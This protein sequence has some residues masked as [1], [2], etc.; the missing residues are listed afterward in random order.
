MFFGGGISLGK[1]FGIVIRIDYS[2]FIIFFLITQAFASQYFLVSPKLDL[3]TSIFLGAVTSLLIFA[4]ALIH[5][6]SHSVVGNYLGAKIKRITLFI[7]GG[8]SEMSG[9]PR[10]PGA[11]F[12]IAVA[13]PLSSFALGFL[14]W[15][16][17]IVAQINRWP[18]QVQVIAASLRYFNFAVGIFNLLPGYPL[19]GGRVLRSILWWKKHNFISATE[20]A[21]NLGKALGFGLM[22]FGFSLFI[23][24][25]SFSGLWLAFI[26]LFLSSAAGMSFKE[27]QLRVVFSKVKVADLMTKQVETLEGN[28]T[29]SAFIDRYLLKQ[30]LSGYPVLEN[31]RLIGMI[32]IDSIPGKGH[33]SKDSSVLTLVTK[34]SKSQLVSPQIPVLQA[35]KTMGQYQL[36]SLPVMQDG[37]LV[38]IISQTDINHFLTVKSIAF[39]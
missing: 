22:V 18:D 23:F 36:P 8:A 3:I 7:F 15:G 31:E 1:I 10:S 32:Y 29:V 4:C 27:S 35:L 20:I 37:K 30:R 19:D 24:G 28:L 6:L 39:D 34:L 17:L 16:L 38:G 11:E 9:E 5:E 13:G 12:V 33:I 2:W 26:G 25:G 21:S 14:M